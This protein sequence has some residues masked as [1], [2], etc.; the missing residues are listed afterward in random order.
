[1]FVHLAILNNGQFFCIFDIISILPP[2]F[3]K[4]QV[5]EKKMLKEKRGKHKVKV[6]ARSVCQVWILNV[7]T[8]LVESAVA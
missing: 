3:E 4:L 5:V 2:S 6:K 1:M 7:C 8:F